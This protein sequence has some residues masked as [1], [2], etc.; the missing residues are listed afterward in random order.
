MRFFS[1][2]IKVYFP[3]CKEFFFFFPIQTHDFNKKY[4]VS[5]NKNTISLIRNIHVRQ[6]LVKGIYEEVRTSADVFTVEKHNRKNSFLTSGVLLVLKIH[7]FM[8]IFQFEEIENCLSSA[9]K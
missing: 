3:Y 2:N 8:L 7:M 4:L 5:R 6:V 1:N 9:K